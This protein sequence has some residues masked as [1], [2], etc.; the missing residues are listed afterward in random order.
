[1]IKKNIFKKLKFYKNK[2]LIK[3]IKKDKNKNK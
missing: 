1:M 3:S 2:I